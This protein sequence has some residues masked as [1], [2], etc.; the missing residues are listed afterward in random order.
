M[1]IHTK[2]ENFLNF[3]L[4]FFD[5]LQKLCYYIVIKEKKECKKVTN[6][7][8]YINMLGTN[9]Q[10]YVTCRMVFDMFD[11]TDGV[12]LEAR[13]NY[14]ESKL[15]I[16][17]DGNIYL[18]KLIALTENTINSN[19]EKLSDYIIFLIDLTGKVDIVVR[20]LKD[21]YQALLG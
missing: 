4:N 7:K 10:T 3:P 12:P 8:T 1:E 6:L 9:E 5:F 11:L 14:F 2:E 13:Q 18:S 16:L 19:G 21:S 15:N 17:E 20:A